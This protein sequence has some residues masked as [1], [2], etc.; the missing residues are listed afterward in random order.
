M[1]DG[2]LSTEWVRSYGTTEERERNAAFF[3]RPFHAVVGN[4]PYKYVTD[5][6]KSETYK[7]AWPRSTS[8]KYSL[9]SP[10]MERF[11]LLP[12]LGGRIGFINSNNFA[13]RSFGRGVV[14]KV[15][16]DVRLD[17]VVDT[18]G[19]YLP[20]HGTPTVMIFATRQPSQPQHPAILR[21][22]RLNRT[23]CVRTLGALVRMK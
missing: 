17:L 19:V 3:A 14:T 8:G 11:L 4:P 1:L 18:S 23:N 15:F 12:V 16:R 6:K 9:S 5:K 10:M 13:K 20:G 22:V 2:R 21:L 7:A